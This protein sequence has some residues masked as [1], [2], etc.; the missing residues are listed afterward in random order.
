MLLA[1]PYRAMEGG[2]ATCRIEK[3][4][5]NP[6]KIYGWIFLGQETYA[7]LEGRKL[8][9]GNGARAEPRKARDAKR[10]SAELAK[11]F[12]VEQ[13][14]LRPVRLRPEEIRHAEL[15]NC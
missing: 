9:L 6:K 8:P 12:M 11:R 13:V 1:N 3:R 4:F 14:G 7:G 15:I 10:Y 5:C 2:L